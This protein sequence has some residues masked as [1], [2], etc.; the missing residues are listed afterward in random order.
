MARFLRHLLIL[1]AQFSERY[2]GIPQYPD[3]QANCVVD[4]L[5]DKK[6]SYFG[7]KLLSADGAMSKISDLRISDAEV[8]KLMFSKPVSACNE[9]H[10]VF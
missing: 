10:N 8:Q 3:M 6:V 9:A 7:H 2:V 4:G 1:Q 5:S